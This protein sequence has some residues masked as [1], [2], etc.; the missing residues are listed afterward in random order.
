MRF[1]F[2]MWNFFIWF[3]FYC[4][5]ICQQIEQKIKW[6]RL[7]VYKQQPNVTDIK[8]G[9][10]ITDSQYYTPLTQCVHQPGIHQVNTR[11]TIN[12]PKTP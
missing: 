8:H 2:P 11:Y 1:F 3:L 10:R 12:I 6:S 5:E 9:T 7:Q 4:F